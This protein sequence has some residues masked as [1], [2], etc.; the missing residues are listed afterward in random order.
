MKAYHPM[1]LVFVFLLLVFSTGFN[2]AFAKNKAAATVKA[3]VV[4]SAKK[5]HHNRDGAKS[6]LKT[7]KPK[8][9]TLRP[10]SAATAEDKDMQKALDLSLSINELDTI[11]SNDQVNRSNQLGQVSIFA[12]EK[13][14]QRLLSLDGQLLMSQE[15][16]ADKKKSMDGAGISINIK[17]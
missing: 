8:R 4:S 2:L 3:H 17:R 12:T 13:K 11:G 14:Q 5:V 10:T 6:V 1:C 9:G 15:P 7:V 16:E